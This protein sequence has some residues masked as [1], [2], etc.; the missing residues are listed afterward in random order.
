[1]IL[2]CS[3]AFLLCLGVANLARVWSEKRLRAALRR[4]SEGVD[5]PTRFALRQLAEELE[6]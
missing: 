2:I 3:L 6:K 1:M 5:G 4:V